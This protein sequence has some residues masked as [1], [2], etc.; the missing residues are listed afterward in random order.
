MESR[1]VWEFLGWTWSGDTLSFRA[2]GRRAAGSIA[3]YDGAVRL[4]VT[5]P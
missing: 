3:I 4:E 2:R 1:G 5:L